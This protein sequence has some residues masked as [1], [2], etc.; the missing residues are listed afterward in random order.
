MFVKVV[1]KNDFN[2]INLKHSKSDSS[3]IKEFPSKSK[4]VSCVQPIVSDFLS[5]KKNC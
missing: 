1:P 3:D 5:E 2:K 4:E